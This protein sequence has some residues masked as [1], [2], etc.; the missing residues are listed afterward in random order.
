MIGSD[1]EWNKLVLGDSAESSW[2][3]DSTNA[4]SEVIVPDDT[5]N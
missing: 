4:F 1:S 3:E 2:T 5:L